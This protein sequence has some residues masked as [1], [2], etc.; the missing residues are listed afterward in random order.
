MKFFTTLLLALALAGTAWAERITTEEITYRANGTE[1]KGFIAYD[2]QL[3][4]QRPGV[5]V[6]HEWWGHNEYVR[7]RAR[8]LAELG[9]T[10]FALDMYGDGKTADHPDDAGK[11]AGQLR[12][13]F[14]LS[15]TRFEAALGRLKEHRTV[16]PEQV[17]AIGY[18]FGGGVVLEMARAGV[19][20]DA[21]V[22]FHGTLAASRPAEK[23]TLTAAV[24]A[25][26][27]GQDPMVPPEQVTAFEREMQQAG[28]DYEL[29]VFP[30]ATH[31]FTNPRA[32][33]VGKKFGLPLAYDEE[34]DR[35]SWE[36]MQRL[37]DRVFA[38]QAAQR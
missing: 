38:E 12:E 30:E 7:E 16:D 8:M 34:A 17:A 27:G 10:A 28:A 35:K 37:F 32:T 23:G 14:E 5:L 21:V 15:R 2:A 9:Y 24:L 20:L 22:S 11:F 25:A 6:V 19:D 4:G 13:N 31:S 1:L 18:C 26:T 29:I 33:E 36:A 3:Q